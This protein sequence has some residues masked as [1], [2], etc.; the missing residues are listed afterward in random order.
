MHIIH[1]TLADAQLQN[2][3]ILY[4]NYIMQ[5]FNTCLKDNKRYLVPDLIQATFINIS[6]MKM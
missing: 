1:Y 2:S 5:A 6:F 4:Y 3:L